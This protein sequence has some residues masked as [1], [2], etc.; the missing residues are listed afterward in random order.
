[1]IGGQTK[2]Q[3]VKL[4]YKTFPKDMA[5][6]LA[7][8]LESGE[9]ILEGLDALRYLDGQSIASFIRSEYPQTQAIV[10]AYLDPALSGEVI[11]LLPERV[12][13]EVIMRLATLDRVNPVILKELDEVIKA[14]MLAT[15]AAKNT[16]IGGIECAAEI[17]NYLDKA[18]ETAILS[19]VEES[20][21][22]L[23]E[24]IRELMFVFEDLASLDDRGI[25]A[26]M[27]EVSNDILTLAL[28]TAS[29]ELKGKMLRNISQRA[30]QM[31]QEELDL[32]GPVK[33]TDVEH[34]QQEIVKIARRLEEE[35]KIVLSGKGG[36]ETLV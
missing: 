5:D 29:E 35:G 20:N 30:A 3:M 25:Q 16:S 2:E 34:A 21:P 18:S 15:G 31:I 1:M 27:K 9:E 22:T 6:D 8:Y 17:M 36:G 10:L 14:E 19:Q 28:K 4:I 24:E 11:G 32:M 33:L 12:R 23:V 26:I 13:S 7:E